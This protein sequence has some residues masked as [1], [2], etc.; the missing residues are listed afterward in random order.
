MNHVWSVLCQNSSVDEE[1]KLL[2][3]F[4]CLEQ[5]EITVKKE[6]IENKGKVIVP[7]LS[8]LISFWTIDGQKEGDKLE[9]KIESLDPS[10]NLL[11]SAEKTFDINK[12]FPRFRSKIKL[13]GLPVTKSGRYFFKISQKDKIQKKFKTVATLPLDVDLRY[14]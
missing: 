13:Q 14:A 10:N 6:D 1:T 11:Y 8:E 2:S 5:V 12:N 7:I 3:I 4:N 9:M